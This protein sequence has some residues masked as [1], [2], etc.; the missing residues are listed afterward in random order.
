MLTSFYHAHPRVQLGASAAL[1]VVISASALVPFVCSFVR[2]VSAS[3]TLVLFVRPLDAV[4]SVSELARP[5]AH[6]VEVRPFPSGGLLQHRRYRVFADFLQ[7]V[8]STTG[9]RG[10]WDDGIVALSDAL[11]VIF[12]QDP[13][14]LPEVIE[15]HAA[16]GVVFHEEARLRHHTLGEHR[17]NNLW[18]RSL[19]GSKI[20]DL[21]ALK[22]VSCSGFSLGGLKAMRFY[23]AD[24]ASQLEERFDP[25][26]SQLT[27]EHGQMI[28]RGFD[29]G[30]HNALVYRAVSGVAL[31]RVPRTLLPSRDGAI[32]T[33]YK[34]RQ[35]VDF[36][37]R[38]SESGKPSLHAPPPS[39]RSF[40]VVHQYTRQ[41]QELATAL[42]CGPMSAPPVTVGHLQVADYCAGGCV[43]L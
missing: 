9:P 3:A 38:R 23:A 39:N 34:M 33:A 20:A 35:G 30:V 40:A 43:P 24:M 6:L 25:L 32:M 22:P 37:V 13:F 41:T 10:T 16:R 21:L 11:D 19:Y 17:V 31:D 12:Q 42:R 26:E 28:T 36:V 29:Q 1:G 2:H 14:L 15:Q 7:E 8:V 4:A 5:H 18:V 27:K